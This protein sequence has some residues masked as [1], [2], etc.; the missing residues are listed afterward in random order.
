MEI[1]TIKIE[2]KIKTNIINNTLKHNYNFA[3]ENIPKII[4]A[5]HANIPANKRISYGIVHTIKVLSQYLF[6]QLNEINAPVFDIASNIFNRS[7]HFKSKG[8]AL[9]MISYYGLNDFFVVTPFFETSAAFP[10]WEL[11]EF[12]Q[13]FFRKLIKKHP[14]E[15]SGFLKRLVKSEDPNVR[16]FVSETLRPVQENKWFFE[17]PDYSLSILKNMFKESVA[18]PRTSVSN[19][20]SDLARRLPELVYDLVNELVQSGDKNSYWIAY[21][22]CRNLIKNDPIKVMDLLKVD[23]YKYKKRIHKKSDYQRN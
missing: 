6:K 14:S 19:N 7:D 12:A 18:F 21:R 4:E 22:A 8:V 15:A 23:E 10:H 2:N 5:L 9:G 13:M 20:L 17:N 16:R 3:A 11:R 1:L